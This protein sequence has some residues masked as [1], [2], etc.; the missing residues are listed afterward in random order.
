MTSCSVLVYT[1]SNLLFTVI[2]EVDVRASNK[3]MMLLFL[4]NNVLA[5]PEKPYRDKHYPEFRVTLLSY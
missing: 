3:I 4:P 5:S 1:A 2:S